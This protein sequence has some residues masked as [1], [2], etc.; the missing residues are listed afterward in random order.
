MIQK[1]Q[2]FVL[3]LLFGAAIMASVIYCFRSA[4][5]TKLTLVALLYETGLFI[6]FDRI[7]NMRLKK[8]RGLVYVVL[9][10][11]VEITAI[12]LI[13]QADTPVSFSKWFYGSESTETYSSDYFTGLMLGGGFFFIS[14]LYYFTQIIYRSLGTLLLIMFSFAI[15]AK[16][17]DTMPLKYLIPILVL[18][19]SVMV[20]NRQMAVSEKVTVVP[21]KSYYTSVLL[22]TASVICITLVVPK[23]NI[24]SKQERDARFLNIIDTGQ[25]D[26]ITSD[27]I[28]NVSERQHGGEQDETVLFTVQTDEAICYL[29]R[30]SFLSYRGDK[31]YYNLY[32]NDNESQHTYVW[33]NSKFVLDNTSFSSVINVLESYFTEF[34]DSGYG[35]KLEILNEYKNNLN[36]RKSMTVNFTNSDYRFNALSLPNK[37]NSV[38]INGKENFSEIGEV[39]INGEWNVLNNNR[40]RSALVEYDDEAEYEKLI[41]R[42]KLTTEEYDAII[43][44]AYKNYRYRNPQITSIRS[45]RNNAELYHNG[46]YDEYDSKLKQ[47]AVEITKG[48]TSDYDKAT[49]L[50][51]YFEEEGFVYDLSYIPDDIS[52]E[53]FVFESKRG[54][55]SDYAT[56]MTLMARSVGLKARYCTGYAAYERNGDGLIV[57]AKN[58]H[59][60]VEVY[61][62]GCGWMTFDPT[63]SDFMYLGNDDN[64]TETKTDTTEI[65]LIIIIIT[66]SLVVSFVLICAFRRKISECLFRIKLRFKD[67]NIF[68]VMI[69]NRIVK[70]V[71][72]KLSLN[73]S[74]MTSSEVS[75]L[76]SKEIELDISRITQVFEKTYYGKV[77]VS[78]EEKAELYD[79]Y[80][81]HYKTLK[82]RDKLLKLVEE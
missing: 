35:D 78:D 72:R 38:T 18:Y 29:K 60:F 74:A 58:A 32:N 50:E 66:T 68:T 9:F 21:G 53:Y 71:S 15:Y 47:L 73:L 19:L 44:Y 61:V 45:E 75:E 25:V 43:N 39:T 59:A 26:E 37:T 67:N 13:S 24:K 82:K 5:V 16:R 76:V 34:K 48:Y 46:E 33:K 79:I 14:V 2:R 40:V 42:L 10:I 3:P 12:T 30:Q 27:V 64:D 80:R 23:P 36:I 62:G 8:L 17:L 31:W 55:C 69:Y 6:L 41:E 11:I 4:D 56:A 63:V 70:L 1:I 20:H 22:F 65:K 57:R 7:N 28:T 77:D 52:I 51:K 81:S 54:I 49:A